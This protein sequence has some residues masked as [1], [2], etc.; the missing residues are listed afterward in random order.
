MLDI[1]HSTYNM[2]LFQQYYNYNPLI[3]TTDYIEFKN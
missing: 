1:L 3:I 2:C